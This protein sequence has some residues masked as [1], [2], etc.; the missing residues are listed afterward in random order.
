MGVLKDC[1]PSDLGEKRN[2]AAFRGDQMQDE[3]TIKK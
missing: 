3:E 2:F 1:E